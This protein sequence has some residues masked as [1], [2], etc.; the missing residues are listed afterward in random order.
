MNT[1]LVYLVLAIVVTALVVALIQIPIAQTANAE[2]PQVSTTQAGTAWQYARLVN[3]NNKV[4]WIEGDTNNIPLAV[5]VADQIQKLGGGSQRATIA[6]LLNTIGK[7]R[8]EL[9]VIQGN[10]W[11]FK[12]RK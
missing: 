1:K 12:R 8:W 4:T 10:T 6:N 7:N 11:I 2:P 9:V 5:T 3:A